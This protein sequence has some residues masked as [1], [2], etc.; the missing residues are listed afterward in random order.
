MHRIV[1]ATLG[2]LAAASITVA[3]SDDSSTSDTLATTT[4]AAATTDAVETTVEDTMVDE[5]I[6]EET[7]VEETVVEETLVEETMVDDTDA[8]G[9]AP[10]D[11]T[12]FCEL[13]DELD[14]SGEDV[15]SSEA[16]PEAVQAFFEVEFPEKVAEL[17]AVAPAEIADDVAVSVEGFGLLAESLEANGW[18]LMATFSDP[19]VAD[20]LADPK[21]TEASDAISAFCGT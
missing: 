15:F 7:V 11:G 1:T 12:A 21:Y 17:I 4:V 5:T 8:S 18:D 13:N 16:T 20:I 19:A 14:N 2:L 6:V 9:D 3:C 10:G